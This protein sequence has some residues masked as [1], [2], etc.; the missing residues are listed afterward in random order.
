MLVPCSLLTYLFT[1]TAEALVFRISICSHTHL[2]L[3]LSILR[4]SN[5]RLLRYHLI[6]YSCYYYDYYYSSYHHL[7]CPHTS[8]ATSLWSGIVLPHATLLSLP[9]LIFLFVSCSCSCF[10]P[11]YFLL[12]ELE[13][14]QI[15]VTVI[16]AADEDDDNDRDV[17]C[18]NIP[19][20]L[21]YVCQPAVRHFV[22]KLNYLIDL[23]LYFYPQSADSAC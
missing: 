6:S 5:R 15:A 11:C 23:D 18:S 20:V 9:A 2:N 14:A 17:R 22:S 21:L 3:S 8:C 1:I 7:L 12:Y 10:L 16:N 13:R 4:L 19:F